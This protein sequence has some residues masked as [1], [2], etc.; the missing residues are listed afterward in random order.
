[1]PEVY[2]TLIALAM[3]C[4]S[5]VAMF[6]AGNSSK[7]RIIGVLGAV[8]SL[9]GAVLLTVN[10]LKDVSRKSGAGSSSTVN[11]PEPQD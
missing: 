9:A 3:V 7:S 1:M 8:L 6:V 2:M 11:P 10:N 5:F 4:G